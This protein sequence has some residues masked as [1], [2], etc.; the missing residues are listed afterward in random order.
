[1]IYLLV[2]FEPSS[3]CWRL[4]QVFNFV[5]LHRR[6]AV[7]QITHTLKTGLQLQSHNEIHNLEDRSIPDSTDSRMIYFYCWIRKCFK[8]N[9]RLTVRSPEAFFVLSKCW[10]R[11]CRACF[12]DR[13]RARYL[14]LGCSD[15]GRS[16]VPTAAHI[17]SSCVADF[18]A[19]FALRALFSLLASCILKEPMFPVW[20]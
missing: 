13:L 7:Q 2:H 6:L 8:T 3:S 1:M 19:L 9:T 11:C 5:L 20:P 16:I 17:T 4:Q 10:L 18:F 15:C 14:Y 12:Q